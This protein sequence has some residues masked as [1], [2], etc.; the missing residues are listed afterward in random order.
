MD[1]EAPAVAFAAGLLLF[2]GGIVAGLA[3]LARDIVGLARLRG[4]GRAIVEGVP[5]EALDRASRRLTDPIPPDN[6]G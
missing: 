4:L 6:V 3:R 2:A 1:L 5:R